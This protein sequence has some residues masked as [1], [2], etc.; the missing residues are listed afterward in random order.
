M[1]LGSLSSQMAQHI[2]LMNLVAPLAVV[3]MLT[4]LRQRQIDIPDPGR[5]I[6]P[7]TVLQLGLLWFWH[8][9]A[10]QGAHSPVLHVAM[11]MSLTASALF[12]W[13][14]VLAPGRRR[15]RALLALLVTGKL[16][17]LL[18]VLLT[19]S[20]RP[21]Y[22]SGHAGHGIGAELLADQQLAGL[23][24]LIACPAT[25]VLAGLI[26]AARWLGTLQDRTVDVPVA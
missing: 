7:A 5:W 13:W 3:A 20:P 8:A 19:F 23:L 18:G 6:A 9:P 25:Y 15:W 12:F 4:Q 26:L 16:F 1:T 10:V 24:M 21:L 2:V 14:T 22:A 11:M 17:C